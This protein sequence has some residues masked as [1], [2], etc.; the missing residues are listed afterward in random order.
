MGKTVTNIDKALVQTAVN[1]GVAA[2]IADRRV[3]IDEFVDNHYSFKGA[4]QL[5]KN[6][7][8]WDIAKAPANLLWMPVH[9]LS[10]LGKLSANKMGW[11]RASTL[12]SGVPAGF[13]TKVE[14]E[15]EWLVYTEFL[16]LPVVQKARQS[17]SNLLMEFI[18]NNSDLSQYFGDKLAVIHEIA[19]YDENRQKMEQKLHRY[20]NSRK[21]AAEITASLVAASANF[22]AH[23]SLSVGAI[24]I[25][26]TVAAAFAYHSA[27]SS[28][29]FGSSLGGLYYSVFPASVSAG[30]LVS[31]TGGIAA[32]LGV[33]AAF[34]GIVAD[35]MQ[36]KLGLHQKKLHKL[37]DSIEK[38]FAKASDDYNL[39]DE[40]AARVLDLIDLLA[41]VAVRS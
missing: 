4:W 21:A 8:G 13:R 12:L 36:R 5:N 23:K 19:Q 41:V 29:A 15:V 38:Q 33:I 6:A 11:T 27:V 28:F 37:L 20:L 18:L 2:Y 34:G 40:Y 25:G 22:A 17:E 24:G 1:D 9:F 7:M 35:P 39:K 30:L 14:S 10:T 16:H 32:A 26:Q 31:V 3:A